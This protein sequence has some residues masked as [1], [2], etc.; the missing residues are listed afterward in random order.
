[1]NSTSWSAVGITALPLSCRGGGGGDEKNL[2]IWNIDLLSRIF[3]RL[4]FFKS[5]SVGI[6]REYYRQYLYNRHL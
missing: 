2:Q 6:E 5:G 3:I 4:R 1:M